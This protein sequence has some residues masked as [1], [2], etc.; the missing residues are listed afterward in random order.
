MIRNLKNATRYLTRN[1]RIRVKSRICRAFGYR[2]IHFLHIGKTG[3]TALHYSLKK[4]TER[5]TSPIPTFL[6]KL[7][8]RK[9]SDFNYIFFIYPHYIKLRDIPHGD[10]VVFALREPISRYV[11]GF[12]GRLRQDK[13]AHH[14][15]WTAAEKTAFSIY[16]SASQ[17]AEDISSQDQETKARAESAM[18]SI[19]HVQS[20]YFE[21]FKNEV[22]FKKRESD[23]FFIAFQEQL[24]SDFEDLK[25]K[26]DLPNTL[27]LPKSTKH[28]HRSTDPSAKKLSDRAIH[29]LES[30]YKQDIEFYKACRELKNTTADR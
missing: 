14:A 20:S 6:K 2:P 5:Y 26:L 15:P 23:I 9:E 17:L 8:T 24:E 30:W 27:K 16:R 12:N 11:S 22:Y 13:P 18:N 21:W 28:A 29:N 1:L 7:R 4:H 3:G 25:Q 19:T 10:P